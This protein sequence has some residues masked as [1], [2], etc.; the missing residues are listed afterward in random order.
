MR[1]RLQ[2]VV[3]AGQALPPGTLDKLTM[4]AAFPYSRR[5][6]KWPIYYK[7]HRTSVRLFEF[8]NVRRDRVYV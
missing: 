4:V 2:L 1:S 8:Q 7:D 3:D 5:A 6:R